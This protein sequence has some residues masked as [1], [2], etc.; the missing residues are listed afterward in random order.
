MSGGATKFA[1]DFTAE[2]RAVIRERALYQ[3][4]TE[5]AAVFGTTRRVITN[6]VRF[7]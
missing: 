7:G 1:K 2:E 5:L 3:S 6:L 4:H